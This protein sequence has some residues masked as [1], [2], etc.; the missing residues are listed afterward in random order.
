MEG[1]PASALL[2]TSPEGERLR[3]SNWRRWVGWSHAVNTLGARI[4]SHD[5]RHTCA[6]MLIQAGATV[7][8]GPPHPR[9]QHTGHDALNWGYLQKSH[10]GAC[11][12]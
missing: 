5:L 9:P 2:F 1:R 8:Q 4:R 10:S 3:N 6:S 11:R 12:A 7:G